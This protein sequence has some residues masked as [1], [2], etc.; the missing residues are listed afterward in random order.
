MKKIIVIVAVA[1]CALLIGGFFVGVLPGLGILGDEGY[2]TQKKWYN[3]YQGNTYSELIMPEDRKGFITSYRE[4]LEF[5]LSETI[6]IA[7]NYKT[8]F[9]YSQ[10]HK[11]KYVILYKSSPILPWTVVSEPGQTAPFITVANPGLF[12]PVF[13]TEG[14]RDCQP[15]VFNIRGPMVGAIRAELWGYFDPN[16]F[17]P[18]DTWEWHL[19]SSDQAMLESGK[20]GMWLPIESDGT[21]QSTFEI[22]ETV[23]IKVE[24]GVGAPD[25]DANARTGEKTWELHLI[26]PDGNDYTGQNFPRHLADHFQGTVSF[27]VNEDMFTLGGNNRYKLELYNTLWKSGTL[28]ISAVDFKAKMPDEP[29]IIPNCGITLKVPASVDVTLTA[30]PNS[31]TQLAIGSFGVMVWYG[32][33][34]DLAPGSWGDDRWILR[35]TTVS[36]SKSGDTYSAQFSFDVSQPDRYVTIIAYTHDT[37]GR[38]SNT[39]YY[40]IETYAIGDTEPDNPDGG[41]GSYGGGTSGET[42]PWD[43]Q[44]G[45]ITDYLP[46]IIAIAVF[47]IMLIVAF[48]PQIP[49]PYGIYGR[50]AVVALGALLA[51]VIYWRLGGTI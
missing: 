31:Q 44:T 18:F 14:R 43:F 51:V 24:T 49:I 25:I 32:S 12:D 41:Q 3:N 38:D 40:Q 8:Q 30:N 39:E 1:V 15:Y 7:G 26:S 6:T 23:N 19:L 17:D 35:Q 27:V 4:D 11:I 36:A 5:G 46:L 37:D 45:E 42:T 29:V 33:H 21:Y 20:C 10:I 48:I 9:G 13:S 22:D 28:E 2:Q 16:D 34:A 50:I 47:I